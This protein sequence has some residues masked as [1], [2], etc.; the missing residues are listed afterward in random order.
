[1]PVFGFTQK[2]GAESVLELS[3]VSRL[4][5]TSRSESPS[6]CACWRS[7]STRS[8][9][10][11]KTCAMCASWAPGTRRT[12]AMTRWAAASAAPASRPTTSTSSCAGSPNESTW[13]TTSAGSNQNWA[14]G[15]RAGSSRRSRSARRAEGA[16]PRRSDTRISASSPPALLD[17]TNARLY[18]TGIPML[19]TTLSTSP[20]ASSRTA[21]STSITWRSVTSIRV[22]GGAR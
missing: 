12:R 22:P 3:E 1:M 2:L 8:D 13:L 18:E 15:K 6:D 9:G 5:A 17:C 11:S 10:R 16:C 7:T 19:S 14:P 21:A 4:V 20:R